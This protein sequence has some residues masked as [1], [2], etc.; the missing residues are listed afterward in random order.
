MEKCLILTRTIPA[1]NRE[2]MNKVAEELVKN[3][4]QV[5][6][7]LLDSDFTWA[8]HYHGEEKRIE[9]ILRRQ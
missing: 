6:E 4:R 3:R 2:Y 9:T 7:N 5:W 8:Y 1:Q